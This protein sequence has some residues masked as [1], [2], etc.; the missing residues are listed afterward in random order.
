MGKAILVIGEPGTGKTRGIINLPPDKTVIVSPNN[1]DLPFKGGSTM[2][3]KEKNNYFRTVTFDGIKAVIEGVDK[4]MPNVKYII[5]EDLTH[6]LSER[7]MQDAKIKSYDKWTDLGVDVF[8][9][10]IRATSNVREDLWI[11]VIAHTMT[12]TDVQG[13]QI[14]TIQTAGKLLDNVIKIPSYFTYVLHT[15]PVLGADHKMQYRFL[16]NTDGVRIA[17]S[18]EGCLDLHEE[19]DYA[20]IINK[21]ETYQN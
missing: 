6:Y 17:K 12:S 11:I 20:Q 5:I 19:N 8:N 14:I 4:K 1:K 13:N 18:P 9:A 16:T 21:I 7:V 2:Y 15:D 10:L 3:S